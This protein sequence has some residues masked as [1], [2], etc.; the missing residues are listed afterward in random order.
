MDAVRVLESPDWESFEQDLKGLRAEVGSS[1]LLFR[2]QAN[3]AWPLTT[4]LERNGAGGI[5]FTEYHRLICARV[6]PQVK[7]LASVQ[8]PGYVPSESQVIFGD[9]E[10]LSFRR[11]PA[12]LY[13]YMVYLRHHGFPSPLLDWSQSPFVAAFFAFR[14]DSSATKRSIFAYC[15]MPEGSKGGA[16]GELTIHPIGSYVAGH[17]R[18]F[19]QQCDYTIC[20]EFKRDFGQWTFGSHQDVFNHHRPR[21]DYLWKFNIPSTE[22]TTVLRFLNDYNLNAYSLFGSEESLMETM[23]V[24]EYVLKQPF[25]IT[26]P[27][28]VGKD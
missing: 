12:D 23:W 16:V 2:G 17:H 14:D 24:K 25:S 28:V 18:H 6:G 27:S 5:P 4:T 19:R 13:A 9:H 22:R 20:G 11:F 26:V 8:L 10:L 7:T 21:Q 15:E 3:S 1:R